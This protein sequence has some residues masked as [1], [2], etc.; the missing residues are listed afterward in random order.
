MSQNPFIFVVK[1]GEELHEAIIRGVTEV[2]INGAVFS[3]IGALL[4]P[5]L[6]F[7]DEH[8]KTYAE[9]KFEGLFELL[10]INGNVTKADGKFMAH[11]HVVLGR[12]DCST[13]GGHFLSGEIG[14][15]GEILITPLSETPIRKFDEETGLKLISIV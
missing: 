3:G 2:K 11:S 8:T 5:V 7:F 13:F 10:S 12:E 15:T 1:K 9:K 6:G 14:V 4:N